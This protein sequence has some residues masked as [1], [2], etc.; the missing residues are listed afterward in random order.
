MS[1]AL[2]LTLSV[3]LQLVALVTAL[4]ASGQ[5]LGDDSR[6]DEA[7]E[8]V[9]EVAA[10]DSEE[11]RIEMLRKL[12]AYRYPDVALA[13]VQLTE[14]EQLPVSVLRELE[15]VLVAM[16]DLA[17]RPLADALA[18][19]R[20][21]TDFATVVWKRIARQDP[22]LLLPYVSNSVPA[23]ARAAALAIAACNHPD[24]PQAA[25]AAFPDASPTA[26]TAL[27]EG[28][29]LA[30][31]SGCPLLLESARKSD[32]SQVR[33]TA[34]AV[35]STNSKWL[36]KETIGGALHDPDINVVRAAL[37]VLEERSSKGYET[38]LTILL[39]LNYEDVQE[40]ALRSLARAGTRQAG[41]ALAE[42]ANTYSESSR[43][44]RTAR[45]L[46]RQGAG[47]VVVFGDAADS[48][49]TD[50]SLS[51][52]DDGRLA[53]RLYNQEGFRVIVRGALYVK[54]QGMPQSR[55]NVRTTDFSADGTLSI[56]VQ[57][58]KGGPPEVRWK[59]RDGQ[60]LRAR[61]SEY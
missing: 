43:L 28:I 15:W 33:A 26:Q 46:V 18:G 61:I 57:C 21:A 47:E 22:A 45:E 19:Q 24:A 30:H 51:T 44:G 39:K 17:L 5:P 29:C 36:T 4:P 32:D 37:T 56:Q 13:L 53:L 7:I 20:I 31:A 49:P 2:T 6:L 9:V 35:A 27:L 59:R 1:K 38:D 54:C 3:L 10:A 34:L 12:A 11:T 60:Q 23:V 52:L 55:T 8:L 48:L 58:Q 25:A 14:E 50:A 16:G 40:R 41:K 42:V